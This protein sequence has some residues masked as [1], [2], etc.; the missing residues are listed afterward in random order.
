MGDV[1]RAAGYVRVSTAS[2]ARGES[3]PA[4]RD[5]VARRIEA[6]GWQ[7]TTIYEDAGRSGRS[8]DTRPALQTLLGELDGIDRL[9]I[10]RLDRL[11]RSAKDLF[12]IYAELEDADVGLVSI[13]DAFDTSTA[14]GRML[15]A[16]LSAVA[17]LE[18]DRISE[19]LEDF[20]ARKVAEGRYSGGPRPY[21][22]AF[23]PAGLEIVAAE[24]EIVRRIFAEYVAGESMRAIAN[25]LQDE[26]V[27][28]ARGGAWVTQRVRERLDSVIYR[29]DLGSRLHDDIR[30]GVHEAIISRE[31]FAKAAARHDAEQARPGKGRGRP[32]TALLPGGFLRCL[33]CGESMRPQ[34]SRN[35]YRCAGRDEKRSGCAMVS[36]P[37]DKVD[38]ALRN[39]F[40]DYVYDRDASQ[41]EYD[42]EHNRATGEARESAAAAQRDAATAAR[43]RETILRRM[44]DDEITAAEW[45]G[46][47]EPLAVE[48][49]S[50]E[51]RA[52]Y[53]TRVLA[54]LE[55]P[56]GARYEDW[57]A[58]REDVLGDLSVDADRERLRSVLL[59][60]FEFI[61]VGYLREDA[62][63]VDAHVPAFEHDGRRFVLLLEERPGS[64]ALL[65]G[66]DDTP[67]P[68]PEKTGLPPAVV[69]RYS[70]N[71][72]PMRH[73]RFARPLPR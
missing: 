62:E 48:Q 12:R 28:T 32:T 47:D 40:L 67:R 29:G 70:R 10:P 27:P 6:E 41:R 34:A 56:A 55:A 63:E 13:G 66:P 38:N 33:H 9:V 68:W 19:R 42:D 2:Q 24:A 15:R 60:I 51:G 53:E 64:G 39:Y 72:R 37:R 43:R 44:Q 30:P 58:L 25:R 35:A 11:G 22:Y 8:S 45:R 31:T 46:Q 52:E 57:Q 14:V 71:G 21:G 26:G 3:L 59:R 23:G 5:R 4:Q 1:I 7:L 65:D 61:G 54:E 36:V 50:A 18:S 17:E 20:N 69:E 49:A 16:V 73:F